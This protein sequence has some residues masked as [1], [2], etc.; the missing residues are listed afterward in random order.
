MLSPN[1]PQLIRAPHRVPYT[2]AM[3]GNRCFD[4]ERTS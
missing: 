3:P 2:V 4:A 1:P